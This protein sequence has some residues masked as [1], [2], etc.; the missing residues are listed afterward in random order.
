MPETP[1]RPGEAVSPGTLASFTLAQSVAIQITIP[2]LTV[3]ALAVVATGG[4][5]DPTAT[6]R[7]LDFGPLS[8]GKALGLDWLGRSATGYTLSVQ[9]DHDGALKNLDPT[10]P[11][12]VPYALTVGGASVTPR[13]DPIP[14]VI[15][16]GAATNAQGNGYPV[17]VTIGDP[18]NA[19]A[20]NYQ[21]VITITIRAGN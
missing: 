2:V 9:S 8:Q 20:G 16:P 14:V 21:D 6:T 5:F 3:A 11:D 17:M 1:Q 12:L 15:R 4:D 19:S 13:T 7:L 18:G 10:F